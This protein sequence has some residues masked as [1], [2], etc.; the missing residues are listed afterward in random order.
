MKSKVI[1]EPLE[2]VRVSVAFV[3]Q[4]DSG[5]MLNQVG[6]LPQWEWEWGT[7]GLQ[8]YNLGLQPL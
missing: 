8:G 3:K 7:L 6:W 5:F 4:S 1:N 2:A